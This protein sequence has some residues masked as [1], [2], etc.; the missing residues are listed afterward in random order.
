MLNQTL[1]PM[2]YAP[3]VYTLNLE[4][5]LSGKPLDSAIGVIQVTVH[6]ARG[7]KGAKIGGGT[8]DPYVGLSFG[9][10][11]E[12]SRTKYKL[13]TWVSLLHKTEYYL[14]LEQL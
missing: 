13:N 2:M 3:N 1:A 12:L 10:R 8:P 7:I 14:I 11:G 5:M 6:S 9:N 4:Q